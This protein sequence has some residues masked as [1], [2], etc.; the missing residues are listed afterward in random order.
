MA[1]SQTKGPRRQSAM[2]AS[3]DDSIERRLADAISRGQ[4]YLLSQ[5]YPEGY[6]WAELEANVTLTAEYV[7]LHKILGTDG[8]SSHSAHSGGRSLPSSRAA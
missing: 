6:W 5:Q 2:N 3:M 4:D 8:E 7:M 1:I